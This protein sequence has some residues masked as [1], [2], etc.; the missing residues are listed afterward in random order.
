M[1]REMSDAIRC[2]KVSPEGRF[3]ACGDWF[4]NLRIYDLTNQTKITQKKFIEAHETEIICLAFSPPIFTE[5]RYWLASGSRDKSI[6]IY[7]SDHDFQ[8]I[9]VLNQH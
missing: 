6:T 8:V 3:L 4:G 1:F 9:M 7:D 2:V 5:G